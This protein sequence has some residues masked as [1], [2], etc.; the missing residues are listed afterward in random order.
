[1]NEQFI[2]Y[3]LDKLETYPQHRKEIRDLFRLCKDEISEG[4]SPQHEMDLCRND[5]EEL[6][7]N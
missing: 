4:G 5:I 1:M 2:K 3:V 6:I 7:K